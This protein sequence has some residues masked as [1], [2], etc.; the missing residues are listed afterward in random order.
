MKFTPAP[1]F[2]QFPSFLPRKICLITYYSLDSQL[3]VEQKDNNS[4]SLPSLNLGPV[5][6]KNLLMDKLS[7]K[8]SFSHFCCFCEDG[9]KL[10][11]K[12]TFESKNLYI[13]TLR[14][15]L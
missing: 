7:L 14:F 15:T 5:R 10:C 1:Q 2:T 12:K 4:W 6:E 13:N 11:T 9:D 8:R 3:V